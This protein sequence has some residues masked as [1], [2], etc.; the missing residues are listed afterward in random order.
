MYR[1][2]LLD[3][4]SAD[5]LPNQWVTVAGDEMLDTGYTHV[6][7]K[8]GEAEKTDAYYFAMVLDRRLLLVQ[9]SD[10]K[11]ADTLTGVLKP[12]PSDV[13]SEVIDDI[14]DEEPDLQGVFL[15]FILD[16][17]D[18]YRT[19]GY[20]GLVVGIPLLLVGAFNLL[21]FLQRS[22]N[23][24]AHPLARA[25][26]RYGDPVQVAMGIDMQ[27]RNPAGQSKIGK[28][29]TVTPGWLLR[30][31]TFGLDVMRIEDIVLVYKRVTQHRVN[32]VPTG[33]SYA[34]LI[35]DRNRKVLEIQGG[36]KEVD[37]AGIALSQ[38]APWM[39]LGYSAELE[40]DWRTNPAMVIQAVDQ[41]RAQMGAGQPA[42]AASFA[43]AVPGLP[44]Q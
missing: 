18:A 7:Q 43:P 14:V 29:V 9:T 6:T 31:T 4:P 17:Q 33:K 13:Q 2:A 42:M 15:P 12:A 8:E 3:A 23:P 44:A 34:L 36:E 19:G 27:M 10:D 20:I 26:A 1:K 24:G 11:P 5:A 38:R 30:S 28:S 21:R 16:T 37:A 32:F 41:R 22:A 35:N 40:K 25:L 39:L